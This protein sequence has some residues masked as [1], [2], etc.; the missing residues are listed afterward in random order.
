[1][2]KMIVSTLAICMLFGT[3]TVFAEES[4]LDMGSDYDQEWIMEEV[5]EDEITESLWI[6]EDEEL[7]ILA[8]SYDAIAQDETVFLPLSDDIEA[9]EPQMAASSDSSF[10]ISANLSVGSYGTEVY[11]LQKLLK[12]FGY[13]SVQPDGYFGSYTLAAVKSFQK[14]NGLTYPDGI[15]GPWTTAVINTKLSESVSAS[16]TSASPGTITISRNLSYGSKGTEV[17]AV[18]QRLYELGYLTVKPDG[19]FGN[20]T[21]AAVKSFQKDRGLTYQDGIVGPW[22]VGQLNSLASSFGQ[23]EETGTLTY[24]R[25]LYTGLRGDDV[26]AV[27]QRLYDL[28]YLTAEPDGIYGSYTTAAVTAF[29]KANGLSNPDGMVGKWT[30]GV[31][32][33][34]PVS[35]I[36]DEEEEDPQQE[37]EEEETAEEETEEKDKTKE[38][39]EDKTTDEEQPEE[40]EE[41]TGKSSEDQE[42]DDTEEEEDTADKLNDDTDY[43]EKALLKK[44]SVSDTVTWLQR[45]LKQLGYLE[46]KPDGVFGDYTKEAVALFQQANGLTNDPGTVSEYMIDLIDNNPISKSESEAYQNLYSNETDA[47]ADFVTMTIGSSGDDV[48]NLQQLLKD[49][50]YYSEEVTGDFD[51]ETQKSVIAFQKQNGDPYPDGE[52]DLWVLT[53]LTVDPVPTEL[54]ISTLATTQHLTDKYYYRNGFDIRYITI[55]HMAGKLSG[56][57]CAIYFVN[58]GLENSA[59]YC[60]GYDGDISCNVPENFGAWTSSNGYS[61]R[62]S[63]TIEVS[64]TA[65]DDWHISEA[66]QKALINLCTDLISRYDSLGDKM[67]YDETDAEKV[68]ATKNDD[69]DFSEVKGNILVHNWTSGGTTSCPEWHMLSIL[70]DIAKEVNKNL[71]ALKEEQEEEQ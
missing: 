40:A 18:Q 27:Q 25:T 70:P 66:S 3:L 57:N 53:K 65:K 19:I 7:E 67:V 1:M 68:K 59:N 49:L 71:K 12:D 30:I 26:R 34:N 4:T 9:V 15:V 22:T 29:Q 64:D 5:L 45:R 14:D 48:K 28:G 36:K 55:H 35:A 37:T 13:L 16:D 44:G 52:A 62:Q 50:G 23:E 41:E 63:I 51:E 33:N 47:Q 38:E 8:A 10:I 42:V 61:D 43:F 6:V 58:N 21:L 56:E 31:L 46:V 32:N 39:K 60:I 54:T 20:Y 11:N 69:G 17:S 2:K 24:S